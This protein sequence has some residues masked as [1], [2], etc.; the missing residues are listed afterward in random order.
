MIP[1][2]DRNIHEWLSSVRARWKR[3]YD[4]PFEKVVSAERLTEAWLR[5][6]GISETVEALRIS[7]I[8]ARLVAKQVAEQALRAAEPLTESSIEAEPAVV[9]VL[10]KSP[11]FPAPL[12]LH[13]PNKD[14]AVLA[15]AASVHEVGVEFAL[16]V[17]RASYRGQRK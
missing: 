1:T 17:Q 2:S 13:V 7:F 9:D 6:E 14:E 11:S 16:H 8:A 4:E 5:E 10:V 12:T 3:L 15:I